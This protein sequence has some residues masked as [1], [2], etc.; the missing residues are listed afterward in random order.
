MIIGIQEE[1]AFTKIAS[2]NRS[3]AVESS[4]RRYDTE[5]IKIDSD[6]A[7]HLGRIAPFILSTRSWRFA[8]TCRSIKLQVVV[9]REKS[10]LR[11]EAN[12]TAVTDA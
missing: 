5:P 2:S 8:F 9:V 12:D 3:R 11:K 7:R 6:I 1:T 10:S 4:S